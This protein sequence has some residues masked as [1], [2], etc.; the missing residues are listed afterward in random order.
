MNQGP[1]WHKWKLAFACQT[2][3]DHPLE[4]SVII[5]LTSCTNI[6]NC[7][8]FFVPQSLP[9]SSSSISQENWDIVDLIMP[10]AGRIFLYGHYGLLGTDMRIPSCWCEC[11]SLFSLPCKPSQFS[12]LFQPFLQQ[13]WREKRKERKR[14]R[15]QDKRKGDTGAWG[16]GC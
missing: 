10:G 5:R 2:Y 4:A 12:R 7:S 1:K 6:W 15:K 3:I 13:G 9:Q 8:F 14:K 11:E 16:M